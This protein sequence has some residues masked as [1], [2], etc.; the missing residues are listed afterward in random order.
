MGVPYYIINVFSDVGIGGG[1]QL[2][3]V[4]NAGEMTLE[5]M[6][7]ITKQ[8]NFSESTFV[9]NQ[10]DSE[11]DV[12]IFTPGKE[13]MYAGHPTIG[14]LNVIENIYRKNTGKAREKY[15]LNLQGGSVVGTYNDTDTGDLCRTG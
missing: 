1:T 3:V 4:P 10:S 15:S 5:D 14:T 6:Q 12:R 8:F 13:I 11:A 7:Q 2:A 9:T